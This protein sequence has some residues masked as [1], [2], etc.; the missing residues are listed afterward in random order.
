[1]VR[2]PYPAAVRLCAIASE[3]WAELDAAYY[4]I[5]L[6]RQK[7][8]R[9]CNLVYAWCIERVDPE[10][11]DEWKLDLVDLLPWQDSSSSA[12]IESESDSFFAMQAISG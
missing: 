7:P 12:A 6:A 5:N 11:L 8:Y 9:F 4:S 1:V 10:K 3:R 2:P